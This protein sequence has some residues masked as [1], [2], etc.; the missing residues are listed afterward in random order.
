MTP[1]I[2]FAFYRGQRHSILS[3]KAHYVIQFSVIKYDSP[4]DNITKNQDH[5]YLIWN[6][7]KWKS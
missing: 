5:H 1:K 6:N 7:K 3:V 2:D 4:K